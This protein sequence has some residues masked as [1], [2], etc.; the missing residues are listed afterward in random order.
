[1]LIQF[2]AQQCLISYRQTKWAPTNQLS[3]GDIVV[4]IR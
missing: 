4:W 2:Q 3:C 1:V